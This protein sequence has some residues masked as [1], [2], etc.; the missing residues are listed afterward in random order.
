MVNKVILIGNLGSDPEVRH[1]ES[2]A[3]VAKFSI[4]TN[5]RYKDKTGETKTV[6]EWH[7]IIAWRGLAEV[8]EKYLTKGKMIYVEGKLTTRQWQ[9]QNGVTRRTTEVIANNF[10]MLGGRSNGSGNNF[11]SE[12]D[13]PVGN[14]PLPASSMSEIPAAPKAPPAQPTGN[15][16]APSAEDDL[17]F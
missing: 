17:P 10:Q 14:N 7:D 8:A 12:A 16:S 15:P 1:L 6:T 11:P 13:A 9:D 4:A 5:E 3:A 2:G